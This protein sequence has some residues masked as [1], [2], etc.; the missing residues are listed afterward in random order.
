[1]INMQPGG[2]FQICKVPPNLPGK[3][4]VCGAWGSDGRDFVD[5]GFDIDFYGTVYFC[6]CCLTEVCNQLGYIN[7]EQWTSVNTMNDEL[8]RRIQSL[9]AEN[10]LLRSSLS[11]IDLVRSYYGPS[12]D[13]E[14]SEEP[15]PSDEGEPELTDFKS[16]ESD[17]FYGEN[18]IAGTRN[19]KESDG[20]SNE[21]GSS[22]VQNS[23][24]REPESE[25]SFDLA[26]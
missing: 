12:D 2:R 7:P 4:V 15:A 24:G 14:V 3:C 8:I 1:M 17:L 6:S 21:S 26:E 5:F 9:E 10:G 20:S 13:G 16:S 22:D 25:F 23:I 11:S 18:Y 19:N